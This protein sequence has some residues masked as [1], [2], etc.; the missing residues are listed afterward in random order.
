MHIQAHVS[1][2][3]DTTFHVPATARYL[4]EIDKQSDIRALRSD[5]V[6]AVLPWHVLGA[7]SN[8]LLTHDIDGV[9]LRNRYQ[10]IRLVKED[11]TSVWLSVG[12]GL[13]WDTFVRHTVEQGLWG[14]ENLAAIPGTVGAAPVQ[15]IGA[16]GTEVQDA[17]T[18]VQALH[19][20]TGERHEFRNAEC[21]FGYRTSVFKG[22]LK[23]QYIIHR[24][25]FRLRKLAHG[26]PNLMYDSV[27]ER[28][29]GKDEKQLTPLDI[30]EAVSAIRAERLPDPKQ[31]GNAGSFFKNPEVDADYFH[32]LQ[33]KWPDIPHHQLVDGSYK[34]PAAW[35]IEACGWKGRCLSGTD[36]CV[37]SRHALVL[38]NRG[39]ATGAQILQLAE[40]I[41]TDVNHTFGIHLE[42]EVIIL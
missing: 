25:T 39:Q 24:V 5:P 10:Q 21:E 16:Y 14:L 40:A 31:E 28:L 27:R 9:V 32:Q 33:Q 42:P 4:V 6:L 7:G 30:Y 34:I 11:E 41:Q 18:R 17:I 1:L 29:V 20:L 2:K 3:E 35:L 26:H 13:N 38:I 23:G 22:R 19:L 8:V 12:G 15:N 36:A 37:S